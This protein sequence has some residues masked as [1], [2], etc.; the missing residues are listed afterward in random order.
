[1]SPTVM[2]IVNIVG[3]IGAVLAA[4]GLNRFGGFI[5]KFGGADAPFYEGMLYIALIG[6][7]VLIA[8]FFNR[9]H[10]ILKWVMA[11]LLACSFAL[12]LN[13]PAFPVNMQIMM[14]LFFATVATILINTKKT[15]NTDKEISE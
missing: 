13:A 14:G 11:V 2:K 1:M 4:E 8:S 12:M 10:S 3:I 6:I 15:E 7:A 9:S 5:S